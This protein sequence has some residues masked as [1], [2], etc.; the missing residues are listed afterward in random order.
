MGSNRDRRIDALH[1]RL[2]AAG[3][4]AYRHTAGP[5]R[6]NGLTIPLDRPAPPLL[7][8]PSGYPWWTFFQVA[9]ESVNDREQDL[10]SLIRSFGPRVRE[11]AA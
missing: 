10:V 6:P 5:G 9:H 1:D 7:V 8:W 4:Y 11:K 2:W 3:I